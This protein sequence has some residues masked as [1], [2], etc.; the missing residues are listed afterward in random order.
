MDKIVDNMEENLRWIGIKI[1]RTKTAARFEWKEIG[2]C[3][4]ANVLQEL[5]CHR[6]SK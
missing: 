1:W 4:A 5:Q 2:L 3:E 6:I